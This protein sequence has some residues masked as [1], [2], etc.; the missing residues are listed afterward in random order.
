[1]VYIGTLPLS[2]GEATV[3]RAE[4]FSIEPLRNFE[5][6][7]VPEEDFYTYELDSGGGS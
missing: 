7:E 1:M 6:A 5:G 4:G 3:L 2:D